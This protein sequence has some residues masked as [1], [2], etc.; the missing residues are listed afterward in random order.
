MEK[1]RII[2]FHHEIVKFAKDKDNTNHTELY[3]ST[4]MCD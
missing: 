3:D 1:A 2:Y 4:R